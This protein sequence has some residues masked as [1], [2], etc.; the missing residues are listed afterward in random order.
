MVWPHMNGFSS[1]FLWKALQIDMLN[2]T[3]NLCIMNRP[4][5]LLLHNTPA[6]YRLPLF[7]ALLEHFDLEIAF[8]QI[9]K[10]ERLWQVNLADY[11]FPYHVLDSKLVRLNG[12]T[13]L[14]NPGLLPW[15]LRRQY[16]VYVLGHGPG[17]LP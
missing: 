16:D 5:V 1:A 13:L 9:L 2:C 8:C 4:S 12:K 15:L 3:K 11:D 14:L 6:P 7:N 17:M 10:K